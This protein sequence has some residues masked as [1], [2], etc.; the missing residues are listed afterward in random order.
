MLNQIS[1]FLENRAG[2]LSEL[3]GA[4]TDQNVDIRALNVAE[5]AQYGVIRL[6]VDDYKKAI[7]SLV[8]AG[9]IVSA[10]RVAA[11]RVPD[12]PGGLHS[13]LSVLNTEGVDIEY[14]YSMLGKGD[15]FA[16]MIFK[17]GDPDAFREVLEKN[18]LS[19][20]KDV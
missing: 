7:D 17:V 11:V 20:V 3:T 13:L 1:V 10:T 6:I 16:Y 8:E 14:M 15:G 2:Q 9:F 4:L 19:S 12:A 18:G 5:T